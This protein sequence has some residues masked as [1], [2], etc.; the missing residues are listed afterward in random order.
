MKKVLKSFFQTVAF[1]AIGVT[2]S[3]CEQDKTTPDKW[4]FGNG[5]IRRE[6]AVGGT[7]KF[8]ISDYT[9]NDPY[10]GVLSPADGVNQ[11]FTA[12]HVGK[13]VL[14]T[15]NHK[16]SYGITVTGTV[17][18]FNGVSTAWGTTFSGMLKSLSLT[19]ESEGVD[20]AAQTITVASGSE[21]HTYIF[22]NNQLTQ[23]SVD[24][25][26]DRIGE[27]MI[28]T[29]LTENFNFENTQGIYGKYF[30][31]STFAKATTW[32]EITRTEDVDRDHVANLYDAKKVPM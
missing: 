23:A 5:E 6:V 30:N 29:Y 4:S 12:L 14:T 21:I 7:Y 11:T 20:K 26:L 19:E 32:I 16:D 28:L 9:C 8:I 15:P 17:D 18:P 27:T 31:Q 10:V 1:L 22:K 25:D 3:A 2:F 13:C 24:F